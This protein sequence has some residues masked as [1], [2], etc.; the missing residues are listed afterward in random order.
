M[1][2]DKILVRKKNYNKLIRD[3][4]PESIKSAGQAPKIR[5]LSKKDFLRELKKKVV[6]ESKELISAKS[7]KEILDEIVDIQELLDWLTREIKIS[8][9]QIKLAQEEKNKKRGS[10][11]KQLFLEYTQTKK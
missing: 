9:S 1:K 10:F 3:K 8:H 11:K 6:E 7:K 5:K 4:I 2:K